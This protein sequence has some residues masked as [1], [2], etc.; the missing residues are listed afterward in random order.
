M[1]RTEYMTKLAIATLAAL[2]L[3]GCGVAMLT[4]RGTTVETPVQKYPDKQQVLKSLGNPNVIRCQE[5]DT[6][7]WVYDSEARWRGAFLWLV[8][9]PVPL[10][11]PIGRDQKEFTFK[12]DLTTTILWQETRV[13]EVGFMLAPTSPLGKGG[14]STGCGFSLAKQ[15]ASPLVLEPL[16]HCN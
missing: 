9:I 14:A 11:L 13:C 10:M 4:R 1:H 3:S 8:V 15:A 7:T 2:Q 12:H 6:E 5:D 16:K